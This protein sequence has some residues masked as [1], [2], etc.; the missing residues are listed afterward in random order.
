MFTTKMCDRREWSKAEGCTP[1][2][3]TSIGEGTVKKSNVG[4]EHS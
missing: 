1:G 3:S 4:G 2:R